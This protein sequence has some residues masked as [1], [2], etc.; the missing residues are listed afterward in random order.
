MTDHEKRLK[1]LAE[2]LKIDKPDRQS[3]IDKF[4]HDL[5]K[6]YGDKDQP[7]TTIPQDEFDQV[8]EETINKVYGGT[9]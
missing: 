7:S 9:K 3:M 2:Q 5:H 1:R 8:A 4:T 6:I